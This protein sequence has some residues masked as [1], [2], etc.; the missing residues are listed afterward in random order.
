MN[1]VE[2]KIYMAVLTCLAIFS[3]SGVKE[4]KNTCKQCIIHK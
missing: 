1:Q 3:M 2:V 4:F